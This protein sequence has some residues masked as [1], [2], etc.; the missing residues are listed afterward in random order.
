MKSSRKSGCGTLLVGIL[1]AGQLW[2]GVMGAATHRDIFWEKYDP[3]WAAANVVIGTLLLSA[4][5]S[6]SIK[7]FPDQN[8]DSK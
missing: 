2:I 5:V 3:K 8:G 6:W 7:H 4:A 1:G